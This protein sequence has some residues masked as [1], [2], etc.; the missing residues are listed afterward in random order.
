MNDLDITV[1][2]LTFN[3]E[4]HIERC[5]RSVQFIARQIFIVDSFSTDRTVE[6][7]KSIG[8]EVWQHEFINQAQQLQW[9][10]DNLPI[11]TQWVMR[12][13]ADEYV[14]SQLAGE[15]R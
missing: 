3:E 5:I 12:L 8:A 10:L 13:D 14:T 7:A 1:I 9:A 11:D 2:I 15:I 4:M 6:I